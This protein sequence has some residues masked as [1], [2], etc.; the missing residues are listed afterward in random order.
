MSAS[1]LLEQVQAQ[2]A[3]LGH[4]VSRD[5]ARLGPGP[6]AP[7]RAAAAPLAAWDS[8]L[9]PAAPCASRSGPLFPLLPG[10][11]RPA[12]P[13]RAPSLPLAARAFLPRFL[14]LPS[15]R[16]WPGPAD[17]PAQR[18][19]PPPPPHASPRACLLLSSRLGPW[20]HL[21]SLFRFLPGRPAARR[22]PLLPQRPKGQGNK[23]KAGSAGGRGPAWGG[24]HAGQWGRGLGD[25]PRGKDLSEAARF[26]GAPRRVF[27]PFGVSLQL[28]S[29]FFVN[30]E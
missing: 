25:A 7:G 14:P 30:N 20:S 28:A 23:G 8:G 3:C 22:R 17:P 26:A 27:G 6:A 5:G 1:S 16:C 19:C 11:R 9:R 10:P 13:R 2:P 12:A 18:S 21:S 24:E 29:S 15:C 4:C